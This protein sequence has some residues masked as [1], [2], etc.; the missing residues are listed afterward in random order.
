LSNSHN[1]LAG[2]ICLTWLLISVFTA[3]S[4]AADPSLTSSE[5]TASADSVFAQMTTAWQGGDEKAIASLVHRDGLRVTHGGDYQRFTTYSPDQ[6]FYYFQDLFQGH[7]TTEFLFR[8][9]P[10]PPDGKRS[11][12]MV[13]WKFILPERKNPEVLKLVIVLHKQDDQWRMAEFNSISQR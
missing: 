3:P 12:G 5:A 10:D 7:E 9:L 13:E 4:L 2:C 8:R 1:S 11:L 6:A